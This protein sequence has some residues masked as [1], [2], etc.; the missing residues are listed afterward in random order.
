M[1]KTLLKTTGWAIITTVVFVLSAM[2]SGAT[3]EVALMA[4]VVG[5]TIKTP[6]YFVYESVAKAWL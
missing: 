2:G 1:R 4:S 6:L 3:W 5:T